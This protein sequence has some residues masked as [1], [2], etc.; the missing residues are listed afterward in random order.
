[1]GY[2][3]HLNLKGLEWKTCLLIDSKSS[4]DIF[5]N[6]DFP[7][8]IHRAKKPLK[9]PCN[10]GCIDV[11][12][13][14]WFR[15][16]EVWYHP[17]GIANIL[18]LKTLKKRHYVKYHSYDRYRVFKVHKPRVIVELIPHESGLHYL[19]LNNHT[20]NGMMLVTTVRKNFKGF[21]KIQV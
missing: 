2:I 10:K 21:A 4:V 7:T 15:K 12:H 1:M 14:G 18:S 5:N 13:N 3:Y 16:I 8:K 17:K 9:L 19:D 11:T 6:A 20:E